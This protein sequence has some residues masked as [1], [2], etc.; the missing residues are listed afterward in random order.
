MYPVPSQ[1]HMG[2]DCKK[3]VKTGC[4]FSISQRLFYG[5]VPIVPENKM[6]HRKR[7]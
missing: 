3:T 2:K 6:Q 1:K 7:I 5:T 4:V